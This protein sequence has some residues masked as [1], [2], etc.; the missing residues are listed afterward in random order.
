MK[1]HDPDTILLLREQIAR[2]ERHHGAS[3]AGR[4]LATGLDDLDDH[5]KGGLLRGALHEFCGVRQ[6]RALCAR[7]AH[8]A[9]SILARH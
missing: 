2:I 1:R 9:A 7:P 6:D 4:R 3:G 5:L 8:F